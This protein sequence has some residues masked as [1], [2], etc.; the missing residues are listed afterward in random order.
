VNSELGLWPFDND[1]AEHKREQAKRVI[2]CALYMKKSLCD[3]MT[4]IGT[5]LNIKSAIA[6]G[7]YSVIF[8][9]V[10]VRVDLSFCTVKLDVLRA[11]VQHA[12]KCSMNM[13]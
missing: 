7:S 13:E 12:R 5:M 10:S 9:R 1:S 8:L 11:P 3:Y 6:T 4:P 2:S